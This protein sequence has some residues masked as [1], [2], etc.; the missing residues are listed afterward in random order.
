MFEYDPF[1]LLYPPKITF[2]CGKLS[3]LGEETK[4]FGRKVLIVTGHSAIRKSGTLERS[5]DILGGS[6]VDAVLFEKVESDPSLQTV[7]EA[8]KLARDEKCD[9]VIGI[10]GGSPIDAAKAIASMVKQP[11]TI[12]EYHA[13]K[14]VEREGLPFIAVPT[15]AGTGAEVTKNAVLS[16]A[17]KLIKKSVRSPLMIAKVAIVDPELTLSLPPDVTAYTGMDALTQAIESYVTKSSNAI[18]D[19]FALKAVELI[20]HNLPDAVKNG[21]DIRSREKMALGSLLSAMAF[22]NSGL[23]AVHGLAHPIGIRFRVPH[24]LACAILLPYVME[25]NIGAKTD[26]FDDI[27]AVIGCERAEDT[28]EA[29]RELL[30]VIGI[31]ESFANCGISDDDL[32]YI[33]AGSRSNS[34]SK[35]PRTLTDQDLEVL[36]RRVM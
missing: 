3:E 7:D 2:G 22:S 25:L 23:G 24:G 13:G 19:S 1:T 36:I 34:M 12:W 31:P 18:T 20:Y 30:R 11:G 10:G 32:P 33:I 14:E 21:S 9:A 29:I 26:K 4:T 27:A 16:D 17:E 5:L 6:G 15:T 35:N 8:T 28:P